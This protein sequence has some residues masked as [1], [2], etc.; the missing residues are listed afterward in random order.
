MAASIWKMNGFCRTITGVLL[1][2]A[3]LSSSE[4]T[5]QTA[6]S[7]AGPNNGTNG[8]TTA[9]RTTAGLQL[10]TLQWNEPS[11][12]SPTS[13]AT[14]A[15]VTMNKSNNEDRGSS[16][17]T[18]GTF[19]N[20]TTPIHPIVSEVK[21]VGKGE[22]KSGVKDKVTETKD[23]LGSTNVEIPPSSGSS[24]FVGILVTGLLAALAIIVGYF[25]CQQRP[26]T[27]GAK[28]EEE[29]YPVDQENQGNTLAS[30]APL[31][32]PQETQEKPSIN[33]ESPEAVKTETSPP[34]NGHSTAKTADTEL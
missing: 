17:D 20:N 27:K 25:K 15:V 21:C 30:E 16:V 24:V 1:L 9:T 2:C 14:P 4:V 26:D 19:S 12:G 10:S 22:I 29:A 8:S 11:G 5:Y 28:L 31:N 23:C 13:A 3:L 6:T 7:T 18:N 33:G 32:P 34:T